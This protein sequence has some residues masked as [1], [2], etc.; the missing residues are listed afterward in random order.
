MAS[1]R[2]H[3]SPPQ[4]LAP[5][6]PQT[7]APVPVTPP[8]DVRTVVPLPPL[9]HEAVV[10]LLAAQALGQSVQPV[11]QEAAQAQAATAQVQQVVTGARTAPYW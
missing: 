8:P 1:H 7:D 2:P 4:E 10:H 3:H 9:L 6:G 5:V 11:Q